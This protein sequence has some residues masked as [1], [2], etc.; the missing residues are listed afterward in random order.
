MK[1]RKIGR[2]RNKQF[3]MFWTNQMKMK[4]NIIKMN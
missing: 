4:L 3:R 1:I 2:K